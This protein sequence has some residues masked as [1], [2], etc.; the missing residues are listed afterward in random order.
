MQSYVAQDQ[1]KKSHREVYSKKIQE[2][3]VAGKSLRDKQKMIKETH[4]PSLRQMD[5]WRDLTK[6]LE[7]KLTLM[8]QSAQ[9]QE[10]VS[11]EQ[12]RIVF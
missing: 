7:C 10:S 3:E 12:D 8:R 2:Q 11:Q 9:E 1:K 4:E 5:M 6:L